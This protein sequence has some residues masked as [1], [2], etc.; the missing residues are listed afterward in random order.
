[1]GSLN[2]WLKDDIHT[3]NP[4]TQGL[5]EL[6]LLCAGGASQWE[7]VVMTEIIA[8]MYWV[9]TKGQVLDEEL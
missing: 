3:L 8:N 5:W 7:I 6:A 1:M 2:Y 9:H 4:G